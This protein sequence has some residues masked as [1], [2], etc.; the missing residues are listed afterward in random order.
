MIRILPLLVLALTACHTAP[1]AP[2]PAPKADAAPPAP[3]T[4]PCDADLPRAKI[5]IQP[6]G[7][8]VEVTP[9]QGE[10]M[11]GRLVWRGD[12]DGDRAQ[13]VLVRDKEACDAW[14]SCPH[15]L[16]IGCADGAH[17]AAAHIPA[18]QEVR[19]E[20]RDARGWRT[21]FARL[22]VVT[23]EADTRSEQRWSIQASGQYAP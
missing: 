3:P 23:P 10:Y 14:G 1:P 18:A 19:V 4:H 8:T 15:W 21:L 12:A 22:R 9:A 7:T 17:A 2:E 13:D 5:A 11:M 6:D 16:Y 20:D